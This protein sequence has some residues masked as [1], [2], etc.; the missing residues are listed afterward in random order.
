MTKASNLSSMK[1]CPNKHILYHVKD[2]ADN[3]KIAVKNIIKHL[4]DNGKIR[5]TITSRD[6][7]DA[8]NLMLNTV[9][10]NAHFLNKTQRAEF[11]DYW[12]S[13]LCN[14][15]EYMESM[16]NCHIVDNPPTETFMVGTEIVQVSPDLVFYIPTGVI[17]LKIKLGKRTGLSNSSTIKENRPDQNMDIYLLKKYADKHLVDNASQ[18][19]NS[20]YFAYDFDKLFNQ[21]G[22]MFLEVGI[23]SRG[24]M[25]EPEFIT[26]SKFDEVQMDEKIVRL[27]EQSKYYNSSPCSNCFGCPFSS[28]CQRK[29]EFVPMPKAQDEKQP[30][31]VDDDIEKDLVK[32]KN[33]KLTNEQTQIVNFRDGILRVNA[34]A[35]SGKTNSLALRISKMI[36]EG[37]DPKDFLVITFT[38]KGAEEI[39]ERIRGFV[40]KD[41]DIKDVTVST[42]NAWGQKIIDENYNIMFEE[43]PNLIKKSDRLKVISEIIDQNPDLKIDGFNYKYPLMNLKYA[44]GAVVMIDSAFK[45]LKAYNTKLEKLND[46]GIIETDAKEKIYKMFTIFEEKMIKSSRVD[47]ADQINYVLHMLD[48]EEIRNK[49]AKKHI[50]IDEF[51]DTDSTQI[52]LIKSLKRTNVVE[53]LVVVGDDS[54]AIYGFRNTDN[55][56]I[57][58]FH[59]TFP[60]TRDVFLVKNFRSGAKITEL[61]NFVNSLN[62]S[63]INKLMIPKSNSRREPEI[64]QFQSEE[65]ETEYIIAKAKEKNKKGIQLAILTRTKKEVFEYSEL[66]K[67]EGI[68]VNI[69]IPNKIIDDAGAMAIIKIIKFL[70]GKSLIDLFQYQIYV[71]ENYDFKLTKDELKERLQIWG[72]KI[73][74]VAENKSSEE[75]FKLFETLTSRIQSTGAIELK[76][77]IKQE[78]LQRFEELCKFAYDFEYY[79]DDSTYTTSSNEDANIIITTIHSSKG[80]EWKEVIVVLDKFEEEEDREKREEETRLLY[81]AITRARKNLMIVSN[82]FSKNNYHY[83]LTKQK[84]PDDKLKANIRSNARKKN[85]KKN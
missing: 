60:E 38:R 73:I 54:Q 75:K 59:K 39:K 48:I 51:Q 25:K 69:I 21:G 13:Y 52:E 26:N 10:Y 76:K 42:F 49:Y 29:K 80:K 84:I 18:L 6:I 27:I 34:A 28:I 83:I 74:S 53:S 37:V 9:E 65:K 46:I 5:G 3:P 33:V 4:F 67:K 20:K 7:K 35:G 41:T 44:K 32:L 14:F 77:M 23:D 1:D 57:I 78:K 70:E 11:V 68:R 64:L 72:E 31:K 55:K 66:L 61:A 40:P 58:D 82:V 16:V 47:Y 36:E 15:I 81:V 85:G 2:K 56:N 8:L 63:R 50:V 19:R 43:P 17:A 24:G 79:E 62:Q 30:K 45:R 71:R 12:V 22:I